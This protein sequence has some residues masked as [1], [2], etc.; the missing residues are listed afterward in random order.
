MK[1][2]LDCLHPRQVTVYQRYCTVESWMCM[3]QDSF[4][5]IQSHNYWCKQGILMK[6]QVLKNVAH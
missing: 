2:E 4:S 6:R 3:E 1:W 5:K